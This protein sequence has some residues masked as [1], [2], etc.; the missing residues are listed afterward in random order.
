MSDFRHR[1]IFVESINF[2]EL[3]YVYIDCLHN[4]PIKIIMTIEN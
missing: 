3:F 1:D 4:T 2:L